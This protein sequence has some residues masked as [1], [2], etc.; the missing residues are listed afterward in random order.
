MRHPSSGKAP[1]PAC[2]RSSHPQAA[3]RRSGQ[4][5]AFVLPP[6]NQ[7][8]AQRPAKDARPDQHP[9]GPQ[10]E[11]RAFARP[12]TIGSHLVS[13]LV[14]LLDD[15]WFASSVSIRSGSGSAITD[16]VLRLPR[17]FRC[18]EEA[19]ACARAE[20]LQW[21]TAPCRPTAA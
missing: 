6:P 17:L 21:S 16:R 5:A 11:A 15:G 10:H 9:H 8:E 3:G 18:A 14:R 4:G 12:Q 13:P 2:G 7:G 19:A 1:I 20:G